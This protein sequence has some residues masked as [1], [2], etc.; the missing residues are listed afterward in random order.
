MDGLLCLQG[1][2]RM[3]FCLQTQSLERASGHAL[4]FWIVRKR[5][6]EKSFRMMRR[7]KSMIKARSG[8]AGIIDVKP[9]AE[10]DALLCES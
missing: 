10:S 9:A 6:H 8:E 2:G 1:I 5:R 3:C 7:F 4:E